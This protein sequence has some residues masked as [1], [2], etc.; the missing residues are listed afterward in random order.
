MS[1]SMMPSRV[2]AALSSL[3][4]CSITSTGAFIAQSPSSKGLLQARISL[5]RIIDADTLHQCGRKAGRQNGVAVELP[6]RIVRREQQHV[7]AVDHLDD[8]VEYIAVAR[9]INWLYGKPNI[10]A[11]D[12]RRRS[13]YPRHL[14][15]H[16]APG[17]D[18]PPDE[19]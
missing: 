18:R 11:D 8:A 5:Q 19:A 2:S 3:G 15:S 6:M 1:Q 13:L 12:L 7:V 17:L 16:A 4:R 14:G 9:R 10:F